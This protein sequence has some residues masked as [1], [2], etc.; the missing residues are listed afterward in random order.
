[1][2]V[3]DHLLVL[4][5]YDIKT[6]TKDGRKRIRKIAK[7]C[8]NY[9]QRVQNSVF[10]C[11]INWDQFIELKKELKAVIDV[12]E[13]SLRFY[14]LGK[15]YKGKVEHIGTKEVLDLEGPLIF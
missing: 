9:G 15:G 7:I 12:K 11:V 1:M 10:E 2:E 4:V 6:T 3:G 14:R 5:T 13:D 8:L